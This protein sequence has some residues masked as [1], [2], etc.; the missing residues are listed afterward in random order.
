MR[1]LLIVICMFFVCGCEFYTYD[2]GPRMRS[3]VRP[4]VDYHFTS[5]ERPR[6]INADRQYDHGYNEL[7]CEWRCAYYKGYTRT[8]VTLFFHRYLDGW[9]LEG[10][11][12]EG[13][14]CYY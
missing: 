13:H 10:E 14:D 5:Y 3:T 9:H 4:N 11:M 1:L 6:C 7:V 12:I 2:N 8:S